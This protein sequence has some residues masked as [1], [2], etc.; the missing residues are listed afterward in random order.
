MSAGVCPDSIDPAGRLGIIG[1]RSKTDPAAKVAFLI[2]PAHILHYIARGLHRFRGLLL[3]IALVL[4]FSIAALERWRPETIEPAQHRLTG[5][6]ESY[7][8]PI[9]TSTRSTTRFAR[10]VS[11]LWRFQG[12]Y[13]DLRM[14]LAR[15]ETELQVTGAQ[16]RRLER[17]SGLRPVGAPRGLNFLLTEII[18]FYTEDQSAMWVINRGRTDDIAVGSPVMGLKGLVGIIDKV[19]SE[20]SSQV[21]ALTDPRSAIAVM[22]PLRRD[23]GIVYGRGRSATLEFYP[24]R[25]DQIIWPGAELRTSGNNNSLYPAGLLIGTIM[26]RRFDE[27]GIAFG[28]VQAA[29]NFESLEELFIIGVGPGVEP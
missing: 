10:R 26:D 21:R 11:E 18:G 23:R 1:R 25:D 27:R 13:E 12:E 5:L 7:L 14:Q 4:G 28:V 9:R 20:R 8:R 15:V 24:E 19:L 17:L 6:V 16:L 2:Y 22:D 29:E 3:L